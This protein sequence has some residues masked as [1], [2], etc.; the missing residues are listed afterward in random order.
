MTRLIMVGVCFVDTILS[1]DHYPGEDEKMRA[2][3]V[4]RRRGGNCPNSLEVIQQLIDVAQSKLPLNLISVLPAIESA[5]SR[6]IRQSLGPNVNCDACIY[7]HDSDEP[8]SAYVISS[9]RTGSRTIVSYNGLPEMTLDEFSSSVEK[10]GYMEKTYF[11]F[12]GTMPEANLQCILHI[13]HKYP[14][15]VISVEVENPRRRGLEKLVAEADIVFYAKGWAQGSGYTS[16]KECLEAQTH[17]A[18]KAKYLCCTWGKDGASLLTKPDN[19]Y[20][21]VPAL[22]VQETKIVDSIGAGDTFLA[23]ML[24]GILCHEDDWDQERKLRFATELAGLK[25]CQEGF[26]NLGIGITHLLK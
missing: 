22:E 15:A 7:R 10:L 1:V 20:I 12:E 9:Q 17:V 21:T 5:S 26:Q 23:G 19:I 8:A 11:H 18:T 2:S 24:F 13:R 16:M 4:Y 3:S 25:V 14:S 6:F